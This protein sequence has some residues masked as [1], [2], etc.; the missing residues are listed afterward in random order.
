[1]ARVLQLEQRLNPLVD[2]DRMLNESKD[3]W[4]NLLYRYLL[5]NKYV[6]IQCIPSVEEQVR[7]A[8]EERDRL[9]EQIGELGD[10]GLK[11]KQQ[12]LCDAIE[13]NERP[14]PD[15]MLTSVPIPSLDSIKFHDIVRYKTDSCEKQHIDLSQTPVFTYFDHVKTN[16]VYVS[17]ITDFV[18]FNH[19]LNS[20]IVD[21]CFIG[22]FVGT[23]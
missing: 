16:F 20:Y 19:S 10:V 17:R 5:D 4:L 11:M 15:N 8:A 9:Q 12:I 14:P 22:Y 13:Y 3:Y 6:A 23:N 7:M 1:M 2:L 21:V 18:R